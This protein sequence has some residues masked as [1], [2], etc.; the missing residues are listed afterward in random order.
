MVLGDH[1]LEQILCSYD[2]KIFS[3]FFL[4]K[5]ALSVQEYISKND[6]YSSGFCCAFSIAA[7]S[8]S[9]VYRFVLFH[10]FKH[11]QFVFT[12]IPNKFKSFLYIFTCFPRILYLDIDYYTTN[13]NLLQQSQKIGLKIKDLL[14]KFYKQK[15][16]KI[17]IFQK[18][19]I[20]IIVG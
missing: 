14:I 9:V 10:S 16:K 1:P 17:N 3:C 20:F 19:I 4:T 7:S 18:M 2:A 8:N 6:A 5:K 13:I 11:F 12:T 15:K